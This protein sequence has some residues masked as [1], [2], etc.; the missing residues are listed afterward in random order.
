MVN[1]RQKSEGH[2][3]TLAR[4]RF[5]TVAV[6][7]PACGVRWP[8]LFNRL[9]RALRLATPSAWSPSTTGSTARAS[10]GRR[11]PLHRWIT[12]S[13]KASSSVT[14][15]LSTVLPVAPGRRNRP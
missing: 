12:V 5:T 14:R 6:H 15:P 1:R 9:A 8:I 13:R 10:I 11:I 4:S 2:H 7:S 3:A